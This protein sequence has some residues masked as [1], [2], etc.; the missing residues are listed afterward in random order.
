MHRAQIGNV[1]DRLERLLLPASMPPSGETADRDTGAA[2]VPAVHDKAVLDNL[3]RLD[4]RLPL[5][6]A[7]AGTLLCLRAGRRPRS[8]ACGPAA[9]R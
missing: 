7:V 3:G 2:R 1:L 6:L 8:R 5:A 4:D 9:T